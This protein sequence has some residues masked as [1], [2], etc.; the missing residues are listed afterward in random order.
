MDTVHKYP[1]ITFSFCFITYVV[2]TVVY[3]LYL[4]PLA[5]FPG[6]KIAGTCNARRPRDHTHWDVLQHSQLT[7]PHIMIWSEA[8][9]TSG[10]SRKCIE[11]T[12]SSSCH[13]VINEANPMCVGPIVRVRPD[14]L[15]CNDPNFIDEWY[16]QS[17]KKRRE[18]Y[19]TVT[20]GMQAPGSMIATEDH[21]LHRKRR[22][23]LNPYF[24]QQNVRRLEPIINDTLASML[25]R[26]DG[27]A[28]TGVPTHMNVPFRAAT[29][30]IIQAYCFG[31][32]GQKCLDMEDCNEAFFEV[33]VP[34]RVRLR[35]SED[36]TMLTGSL[37]GLPSGDVH[38]SSCVVVGETATHDYVDTAASYWRICSVH[39]GERVSPSQFSNIDDEIGPLCYDRA[40]E[41]SERARGRTNHLSRDYPKRYSGF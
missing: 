35:L 10:L 18:R 25:H 37:I 40:S 39:G 16:S 8:D 15:H 38:L 32:V 30:D 28:K 1:L 2:A 12:V 5:R 41:G 24:S 27:W 9:N 20:Q 19:K 26:M 36:E 13:L 4:S 21:D 23:V 33:L 14:A 17:P 34:Q 29:Q 22:A 6:P 3:R 7:M 11:N 31:A